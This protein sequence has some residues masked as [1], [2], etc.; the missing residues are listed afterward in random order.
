MKKFS[1]KLSVAMAFAASM[2]VL[3][4]LFSCAANSESNVDVPEELTE[5]NAAEVLGE[6]Y[7]KHTTIK[8]PKG[9][10]RIEE[11]AFYGCSAQSIIIPETVTR[12]GDAKRWGVG[13]YYGVF[14]GCENLQSIEIP[15]S[16]TYIGGEAFEGCKSLKTV[17]LHEGLTTLKGSTFSYCDSLKEIR[18]PQSVTYIGGYTFYKCSSLKKVVLTNNI[19]VIEGSTFDNCTALAEI[20]IPEGVT[21][22]G[23]YAFYECKNLTRITL[24]ASLSKIDKYAFDRCSSLTSV[25]ILA[26]NPPSIPDYSGFRPFTGNDNI[27]FYAPKDSVEV[28]K[29]QWEIYKDSITAIW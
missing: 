14:E 4:A 20:T 3:S 16:V 7:K 13:V 24:P 10:V 5:W 21:S 15:E 25:T 27:T 17:T 19:S 26:K 23:D 29:T 2:L 22:I 11:K 8:I 28:Y 18:I 1:I 12:I 6:D 9:V